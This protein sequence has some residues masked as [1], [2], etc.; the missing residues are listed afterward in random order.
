L[1]V[2]N[3]DHIQAPIPQRKYTK[4]PQRLFQDYAPGGSVCVMLQTCFL[5]KYSQ[6]WRRFDFGA[7]A[8][9]DKN[10]ELF[11]MMET[12]LLVLLLD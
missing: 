12:A 4:I 7:P 8:K 11:G 5:F 2:L 3:S 1:K 6:E 9:K 10:L